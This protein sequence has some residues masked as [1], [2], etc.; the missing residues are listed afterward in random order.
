MLCLVYKTCLVLVL[1]SVDRDQLYQLGLAE[2]TLYLRM[3]AES[4]L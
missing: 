2:H 1:M 4:S 3:E